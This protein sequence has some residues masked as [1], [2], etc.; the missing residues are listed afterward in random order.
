MYDIGD[1]HEAKKTN[2]SLLY[3][4]VR[5]L[6]ENQNQGDITRLFY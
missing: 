1:F 6:I 5:F 3:T 4:L 2:I